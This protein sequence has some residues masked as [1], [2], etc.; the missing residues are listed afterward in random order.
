M[1]RT[2]GYLV[3]VAAANP[4]FRGKTITYLDVFGADIY[5]RGRASTVIRL[6]TDLGFDGE[7]SRTMFDR[8]VTDGL[9]RRRFLR[10]AG[11][12]GL[13]VCST[14]LL[15]G[16]AGDENLAARETAG[17]AQAS[18]GAEP[19]FAAQVDAGLEHMRLIP[20]G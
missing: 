12:G 6:M 15:A 14:G 11:A 20:V 19:R 5:A 16:C 10:G 13:V 2:E 9:S 4:S 18:G 8:A 1:A 17:T 3:D 7:R